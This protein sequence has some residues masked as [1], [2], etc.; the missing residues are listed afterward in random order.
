[1]SAQVTVSAIMPTYNAMPYLKEAID[2]VLA[3]TFTD[4]ELIVVDDGST[5][6]TQTLLSQYK[7][8]RIRVFELGE[9]H[10]PAKARNVALGFACGKYI[11][12]CD[13]DD[14]FLP[15]RFATE[16]AYLE[17]HPEIHV[18]ASQMLTLREN[19]LPRARILYPEEPAAIDRRFAKGKM[20][21]PFGAAMIRAWCFDR[22]GPF[23]EDLRQAEDLEW[24]LRIRRGCNFRVLPD[25]LYVYRT[26]NTTATLRRWIAYARSERYAMYRAARF[27]MR[28]NGSVLSFDQFA[29]RWKTALGLH[30]WDVL[31]FLKFRLL[32]SDSGRTLR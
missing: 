30:T 20:A 1:M 31:R 4:W 22:F 24:F 29:R 23:C 9:N 14:V 7:D 27:G 5:D 3:Q 32:P 10:G 26:R 12:P 21:A 18:V 25:F 17:S 28:G 19:R 11:A 15:E 16:V 2:S 6:D 8:S 13:S